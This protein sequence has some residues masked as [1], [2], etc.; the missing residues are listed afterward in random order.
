M[1]K[2]IKW[3]HWR[4]TTGIETHPSTQY[5]CTYFYNYGVLSFQFLPAVF[6]SQSVLKSLSQNVEGCTNAHSL[7]MTI[8]YR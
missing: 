2:Q 8:L 4:N 1:Q 3:M 6:Y 7:E 5:Y